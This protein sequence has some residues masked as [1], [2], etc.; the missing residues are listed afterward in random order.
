MA[1]KPIA[2][3]SVKPIAFA[4]RLGST[5]WLTVDE[6]LIRPVTT[7]APQPAT[8]MSR[9]LWLRRAGQ[10]S[11]QYGAESPLSP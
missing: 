5:S 11:G 2:N 10:N 3:D 6:L 9:W 4:F 7:R 8:R 1:F